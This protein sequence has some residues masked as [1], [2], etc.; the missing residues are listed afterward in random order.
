MLVEGIIRRFSALK[1]LT[2]ATS[3][4]RLTGSMS[5]A[6]AQVEAERQERTRSGRQF[7]GMGIAAG[8][9]PV[10]ALPTIATATHA[11]W[12]A[13]PNRSYIIDTVDFYILSGTGTAGGVPIFMIAPITAT[14]PTAATG[15]LITSLSAGGLQSKAVFAGAYTGP[16]PLGNSQWALLSIIEQIGSAPG[17]WANVTS[18]DVRGGVIIPP[19]KAMYLAFLS[20]TG[21]TPLYVPSVTW[22]EAELD[23]E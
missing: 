19:G 11:L 5:L 4:A 21:S 1:T 22:T 23:L 7:R 16:A 18:C 20:G 8:A 15:S 3:A 6:V 14:L 2:E 13:D 12:N 17:V 10:Q 9:A